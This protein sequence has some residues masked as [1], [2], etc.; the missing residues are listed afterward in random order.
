MMTE[1]IPE[2]EQARHSRKKHKRNLEYAPAD[3]DQAG[4]RGKDD[5]VMITETE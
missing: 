5:A 4:T 2:T 3:P 1:T